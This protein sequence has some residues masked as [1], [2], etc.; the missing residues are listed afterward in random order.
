[1]AADD[2]LRGAHFVSPLAAH[3]RIRASGCIDPHQT[4]S[5]HAKPSHESQHGILTVECGPSTMG[6]ALV[7]MKMLR[8]LSVGTVVALA[9]FSNSTAAQEKKA[10]IPAVKTARACNA[11]GDEAACKTRSDCN[12]VAENKDDK[13]KLLRKAYCSAN[14][15]AVQEGKAKAK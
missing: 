13:G 10:T 4:V 14:A 1:L 5:L 12:W 9:A 3:V 7:A 6:E 2:K 8:G 11:L 15:A